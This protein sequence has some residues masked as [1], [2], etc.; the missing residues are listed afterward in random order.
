MRTATRVSLAL[1]ALAAAT[2]PARGQVELV[3]LEKVHQFYTSDQRRAAAYELN[4]VSVQFRNEIGRCRDEQIGARMIELEPKIDALI[5]RLNAGTVTSAAILEREFVVIDRLLAENHQQLA[6]SGWST[7]RTGS[8]LG[9]AADLSLSA[10]YVVR[11]AGWTHEQLPADVQ[12]AVDDALA[13]S[14]RLSADPTNP[15]SE[16]PA[17][18]EALGK[19][20]K[21]GR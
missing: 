1:L 17:V 9:V 21:A 6:A 12:K 3:G 10:R 13:L 4:L 11:A 8:V 18:I 7:R 19:A 20:I 5:K 2:T 15:P 14:K 16:T